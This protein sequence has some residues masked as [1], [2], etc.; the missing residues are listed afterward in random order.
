VR[1][2]GRAG[3]PHLIEAIIP[4]AL[5]EAAGLVLLGT[6]FAASFVT[7]AFGIGGG[8]MLLAVM[9]TLMPPLAL[10]PV[11][12]VVQTGSNLGRALTTFTHAHWPVVPAFAAGSVLGAGA[13]GM[14]A[15]GIPPALVQIGVGLFIVWSVLASPPRGLRDWPF[16]V[17]AFSSFLTMFFGATGPFV[18]TFTRSHALGRHAHVGTH[19]VLMTV[20]HAIKTVAFGLLGFAFAPWLGFAAAMIAAGFAGTLAGRLVLNRLGDVRFR[21]ALDVVLLVI[22]V[23]LIY[24]GAMALRS[25]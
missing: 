18:A 21:R 6:S 7:V 5:S 8:A 1:A 15:V 11:H 2:R 10:I 17:G 22:A 24:G 14:V 12:G 9:A 23:R 16:A 4:P 13:G 20:Q 19:A 25:G 3:G